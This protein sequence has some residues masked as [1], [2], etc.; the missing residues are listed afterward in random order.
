MF[1]CFVLFYLLQWDLQNHTSPSQ[2]HGTIRKPLVRKGAWTLFCGVYKSWHFYELKKYKFIFYF[3]FLLSCS[4]GIGHTSEP[5]S[6]P[7]STLGMTNKMKL[8]FHLHYC[9][10]ESHPNLWTY[11]M[12]L[13][14]Y[15]MVGFGVLLAH[16]FL[17]FLKYKNV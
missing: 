13:L 11:L 1:V 5:L 17:K 16:N 10:D 9:L 4:N 15:P 6:S 3:I 12:K 14:F 2:V 7:M 8:M